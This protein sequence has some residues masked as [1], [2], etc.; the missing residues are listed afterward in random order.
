MDDTG[1]HGFVDRLLHFDRRCL[2]I[3]T[4][5]RRELAALLQKRLH[6]RANTRIS[7]GAALVFAQVF[8]SGMLIRHRCWPN[9]RRS[10]ESVKV[11]MPKSLTMTFSCRTIALTISA[12]RVLR[13]GS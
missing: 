6:V 13:D 10:V 11:V 5:A 3:G 8:D 2:E 12:F 9:I 1:F 7:R 4:A